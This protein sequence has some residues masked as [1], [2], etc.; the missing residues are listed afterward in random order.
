MKPSYYFVF[1][2]S[3]LL[4]PN[5]YSTNLHTSLRTCSI[6]VLVLSTAEPSWAVLSCERTR[7]AVALTTQKTQFY[8]CIAQTTQKTSHVI[9]IS[10]VRWRAGCCLATSFIIRPFVACAYRGVF[11][12]PLPGNAL[13]CQNILL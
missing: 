4:C 12:G 5:L 13:T 9:T 10:P 3:V 7:I 6:L 11:T 2:H 8:C 1:N